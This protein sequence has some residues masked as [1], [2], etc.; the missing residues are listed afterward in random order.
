MAKVI[1]NTHPILADL[2][3]AINA[4]KV[5]VGAGSNYHIDKSERTV[6]AA[7]ASDL[8]TSLVL[9]RALCEFYAFHFADDVL[10]K[11]KEGT[12]LPSAASVVSLATAI[13]AANALKVA[14][15]NHIGSTTFHYTADAVNTIAAAN[16]S[17]QGSLNTLLNELKTDVNAHSSGALAGPSGGSSIRL[18]DA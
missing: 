11:V 14:H 12:A 7:N 2:R 9:C 1:R 5:Q 6:T 3:D 17:D 15:G 10:H 13:T 4:F 16:A 8:A 18:V